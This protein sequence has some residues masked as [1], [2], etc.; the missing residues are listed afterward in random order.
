[1][2]AFFWHRIQ[3]NV[4]GYICN[5][6]SLRIGNEMLRPLGGAMGTPS[7][8]L[9][10]EAWIKHTMHL[11]LAGGSLW[12]KQMSVRG[13]KRAPV[14]HVILFFQRGRRQ[15]CPKHGHET[16]RLV[17]YSQ[18]TMVTYVTWD[19]PLR[20]GNFTLRPLEGAMGTLCQCRH[21]EGKRVSKSWI[22]KS[23]TRGTPSL[24]SRTR[25]KNP[26]SGKLKAPS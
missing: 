12:C 21:A 1:M 2:V 10:S 5:H 15:E 3:D 6:S 23:Q 8:W 18:G 22:P 19:V 11:T 7:A 14:E 9:V 25:V 4:S 13:H 26:S 16:Q 24:P 17:P 20:K